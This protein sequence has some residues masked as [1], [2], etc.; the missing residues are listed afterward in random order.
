M[1]RT[2][3]KRQAPEGSTRAKGDIL[4]EIVAKMYKTQGVEV[5]RNVFLPVKN[6]EK[7]T[8][9]IDVLITS[10]AAGIPIRIAIECKNEETKTGVEKIDAF[11]GKLK[12]VNIPAQLGI[13]VSKTGYTS[14]AVARA[15]KEGIKTLIFEDLEQDLSSTVVQAFQSVVYLLPT[16]TYVQVVNNIGDT[17]PLREIFFFR[18]RKGKICGSIFDLVWKEWIFGTIPA[19]IGELNLRVKV[20]S[21]WKQIINGKE[22]KIKKISVTLKITGHGITFEGSVNQHNLINA[23]D[24]S[25]DKTQ[26]TANFSFPSG[27]YN[28]TQFDDEES[29]GNFKTTQ[30]QIT[31]INR[32]RTP[33]IVS[34]STY[35]PP[36]KSTLQKL[37]Q[38]VHASHK[39]GR[40]FSLNSL[41]LT[42][43]EGDDLSKIWEP[44]IE[45]HSMLKD[46]KK[47]LA[48][49]TR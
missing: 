4:E 30:G 16:I 43:I 41:S 46:I 20:P 38:L 45:D 9:E 11:I 25:V 34:C 12:D 17:A 3:K 7:R 48:K 24:R 49:K 19:K 10:Q 40:E 28:I 36:S 18:D 23:N 6:N 15:N 14:G 29:L 5:E 22:A 37:N 8:R 32:I 39:S 35:W 42:D 2:R 31:I 33:R 26:L 47:K 13:Y 1:A 27:K 21:G 44:I